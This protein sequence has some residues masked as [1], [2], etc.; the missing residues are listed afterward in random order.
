MASTFDVEIVTP[1]KKFFEGT[2]EMVIV[3]TVEGDLA[4]LK[5]HENYVAPLDVG[6]VK[7]KNN[8]EFKIAAIAGG[9]IQVDK[10]KTTIIT[11]SAEWPEEIDVERA[12]KA[13]EKAETKLK[14]RDS[15]DFAVNEIQLKKAINRIGI[16]SKRD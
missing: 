4:V 15:H 7:I 5:N 2:A 1:D 6:V 12:R 8:N 13:K 3:R 14:N 9:F 10:E 11:D 16:V